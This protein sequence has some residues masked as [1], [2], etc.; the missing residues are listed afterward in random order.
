MRID[1]DSPL[2]KSGLE[3]GAGEAA[4]YWLSEG[5]TNYLT[6]RLLLRAGVWTLRD[7]AAAM[8]E[9]IFEGE[10]DD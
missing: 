6:H 4:G 8:N 1:I 2:T 7:Y 5:F 10:V 3:K 9:V